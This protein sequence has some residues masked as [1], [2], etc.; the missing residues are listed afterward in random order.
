MNEKIPKIKLKKTILKGL[1]VNKTLKTLSLDGCSIGDEG[2]ASKR[3][4]STDLN[5][6]Y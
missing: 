2:I 5:R 3:D 6:R 1:K 4:S